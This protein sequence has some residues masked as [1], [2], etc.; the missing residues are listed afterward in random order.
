MKN[1]DYIKINHVMKTQYLLLIVVLTMFSG[2]TL[3]AQQLPV[4]SQYLFNGFLINP[5]YAGLDGYSAVNLTAREQWVGIPNSPK[6][7]MVSYQTRFLGKSFVSKG[8]A[9]RQKMMSKYT[10]GRVGIGGVIYNDR[11][12][13]INRT[14]GQVTYA[15][16]IKLDRHENISLAVSGLLYQ[17]SIDRSRIQTENADRL[18]D[19]TILNM[20][21]PDVGVGAVYTSETFYG[22]VSID[23]LLQSYLK[24]GGN[25]I[26]KEYRLYRQYYVTAGY[27]Y[28]ID[29]ETAIEP[30]CLI[31]VT[32]QFS[33]QLDLTTKVIFNRDY[34]AG[35]SYRTGSA[36]VLQAGV[37]VERFHF[38]Y[39]FDYNLRSINKHGYGTHEFMIAYKWGDSPNRLRWLNR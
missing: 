24:L 37:S 28:D 35:L 2:K 17:F 15:Y 20:I 23:Q 14:G 33:Y 39:A 36:I 27:R 1:R 30:S 3:R 10:S 6:T 11:N 8:A 21:I 13:L 5:A 32:N 7:Y 29:K 26:D 9:A 34:W 12:G 16:H 18:I 22:G 38:G 31:K 4:F 25:K 19:N